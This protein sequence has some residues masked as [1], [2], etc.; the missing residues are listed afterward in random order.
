M[1]GLVLFQSWLYATARE[2]TDFEQYQL[3]LINRARSDP[4]AEVTRLSGETWGDM[5]S[6][7]TPDLNEGLAPGT[8]NSA[9]KQ[10]LAFN[11]DIIDAAS[12]YS[13]VLLANDAFE[14]TFGGTNPQ[15]RMEAAGFSFTP[16]PWGWAENLSVR[17]STGP[18]PITATLLEEQHNGLFIDGDVPDRGH[19]V[20]LMHAA[21]QQIGIGSRMGSDYDFFSTPDLNAVITTQD[22]AFVGGDPFLTGVAY[23]DFDV[24]S[25]YTPGIGEALSGLTVQAFDAGTTNLA[26]DTT[27]FGSGG[28]TLQLAAGNYDVRFVDSLGMFYDAGSVSI[29]SENV[30]LDAV[31]PQFVPEPESCLLLA[32]GLTALL[33]WRWRAR[34]SAV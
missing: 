27:T 23:N 10:P 28:Y 21:L 8:I 16:L 5:G 6:P 17:G 22:F 14:H 32:I 29:G 18:L 12:D 20:N 3:E 7:A 30:K 33:L 2:P 15:D 26:G 9:A 19:R 31:N 25:F 11:F 13:D 1:F 4:N 24:D 34:R